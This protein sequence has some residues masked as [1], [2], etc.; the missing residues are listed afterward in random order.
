MFSFVP[1]KETVYSQ[2]DTGSPARVRLQDPP[3][4]T[5]YGQIDTVFAYPVYS[6]RT[7]LKGLVGA[8]GAVI[9]V[10]VCVLCGCLTVCDVVSNV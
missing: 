8:V 9:G 10:P 3:G 4:N 6:F 7:V 2:W 5:V 1:R